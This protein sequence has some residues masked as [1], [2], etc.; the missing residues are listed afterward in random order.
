[1]PAKL[2]QIKNGSVSI[3]PEFNAPVR[4]KMGD[5]VNFAKRWQPYIP[6]TFSMSTLPIHTP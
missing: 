6:D 5:G 2:L 3:F 1:M 4:P